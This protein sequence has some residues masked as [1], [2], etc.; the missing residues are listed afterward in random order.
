MCISVCILLQIGN[1]YIE[2]RNNVKGIYE[3]Y[4]CRSLISNETYNRIKSTCNFDVN[5]DSNDCE[6]EMKLA[7][8]EHGIIDYYNIY[9]PVCSDSDSRNFM[10]NG[11]VSEHYFSGLT[12]EISEI[13]CN[14]LKCCLKKGS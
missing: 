1:A 14:H 11:L 3:Y 5:E 10:H 4:W 8:D 6:K 2:T 7:D 9:A 13:N 12:I